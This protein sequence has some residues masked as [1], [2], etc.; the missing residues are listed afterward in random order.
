MIAGEGF[1]FLGIMTYVIIRIHINLKKET[2]LARQQKN[3]LLSVTHELKSPIASIKLIFETIQKREL[4][5]EKLIEIASNGNK[6]AERLNAL[7]ENILLSTQFDNNNFSISK[8]LTNLSEYLTKETH[9]LTLPHANSR[10]FEITIQDKI[11]YLIDTFH[12]HSI[13]SNLI[14]NAIKYSEKNTPIKI[15]LYKSDDKIVLSV[16]DE[17]AGIPNEEKV[18]I[19]EK[20]Y[21]SGNEETRNTKGTGL[22]LYIAKQ[23]TELHNGKIFVKNNIPRGTIFEIIFDES[24]K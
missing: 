24:G 7:V 13:I 18:K 23:L 10:R 19:F 6:D 14:E 3:F 9:K 2:A 17:G 21:R 15:Q 8:Q 12:F 20:F 1:V 22:G 16:A 4:E 11:Y 5:K